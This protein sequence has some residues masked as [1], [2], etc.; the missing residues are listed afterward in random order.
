MEIIKTVDS[1]PERRLDGREVYSLA[2][3]S[4]E[5][6]NTKI[7]RVTIPKGAIEK[8]HMHKDT[9]EIFIFL[10]PGEIILEGKIYSLKELD[11]LMIEKGEKHKIIA[12]NDMD[13]IGI[14]A[15]INDKVITEDENL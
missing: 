9:R 6:G 10:K 4:A 14:K 8:E 13:L 5:G 7:F 1:I 3:Y 11:I 12:N 2:N 15:D